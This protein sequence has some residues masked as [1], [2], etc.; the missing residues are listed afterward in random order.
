MASFTRTFIALP[1]SQEVSREAVRLIQKLH[2]AAAKVRWADAKTLHFT[3][4]F[5]GDVRHTDLA[6]V[7][8]AVAAA[9]GGHAAV[10]VSVGSAGAFPDIQRPRTIW[11]GMT[12][13]AEPIIKLQSAI[14]KHL[15][16]LGFHPEGR[17]FT[18]H[19]TIGRVREG[20]H[21]DGL[22]ELL[23]KHRDFSAGEMSVDKVVVYSSEL[24]PDG[25]VYGILSTAKLG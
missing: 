3:L 10:D 6:D 8:N 12:A 11:L 24:T 2:G 18:P 25:P 9:C 4:K 7:C 13:G 21:G 23:A 20:F 22:P 17:Q 1:L 16:P 19:V 15:E 14:E 5:L